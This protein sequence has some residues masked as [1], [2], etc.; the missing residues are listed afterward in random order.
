MGEYG[1]SADK[2]A[3]MV[4]ETLESLLRDPYLVPVG[5]SARHVH[6]E[7]RH[8]A[9]LFG[10]HYKL[11]EYKPLSQPGQFAAEETVEVIGPKGSFSKVRILG[12]A[13]A[14]T[15][16]ELASSDGRILGVKPPV[17]SSGE[18][19]G[20]PGI[21]LRG[22]RGEVV[23]SQGVITADRH[24]HMSLEDARWFRVEDGDKVKVLAEGAKGGV[25]HQVTIRVGRE[26]RLDFHVDTD[27]ANAFSLQQ[28]QLVRVLQFSD[29]L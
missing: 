22:P 13:R 2:I 18:L 20:T 21:L 24:I 7:E 14:K 25:F 17:R 11:A 12:P 15:Q 3:K 26:Y 5:I 19:A 29:T 28:G 6:L 8:I 23:L 10:E 27:D 1:L 4:W 16:V 9:V